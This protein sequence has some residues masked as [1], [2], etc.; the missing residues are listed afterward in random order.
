[1]TSVNGDIEREAVVAR[2]WQEHLDAEFPAAL[3]GAELQGVDMVLIDAGIAGCMTTWR[4]NGGFLD[5][6]RLRILRHCVTELDTVLPLLTEPE[7]LRYYER[8]HQLATLTS[9]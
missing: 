9:Q 8:L 3:R 7:E 5:V 4:G 2:L 1:M 6:E